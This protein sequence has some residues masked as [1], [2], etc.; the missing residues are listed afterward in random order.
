MRERLSAA[1]YWLT[2]E[3]HK[4]HE[5]SSIK[6]G[7]LAGALRHSAALLETVKN[8]HAARGKEQG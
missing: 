7:D 4:A 6:R 5:F 2:M 8:K 1:L 3:W